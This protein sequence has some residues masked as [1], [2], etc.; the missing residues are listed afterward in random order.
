M[1]CEM[2]TRSCSL[3]PSTISAVNQQIPMNKPLSTVCLAVVTVS[4]PLIPAG[5]VQAAS[6][7]VPKTTT[8][9]NGIRIAAVFFPE[10]TNV[11]IFTFF[12]LGLAYDGPRQAQWSHLVEHLVIRSTVPEGLSTANAETMPDSL[13]LDFY[14][15]V[16]NWETGLSQHRRWLEGVPFT[17]ASLQREKPNVKSDCGFTARNLA[18]HKFAMA[19]WAQGMRHGETNIALLGDIDR[20]S[21]SQIQAYRD[22]HLALLSNVV[23]CV[24]GGVQPSRVLS[25]ASAR[26]GAIKSSATPVAPVKL[27]PGNREMTWDLNARH[28]IITWPAP[29]TGSEDFAPLMA[30]GQWL[31]MRFFSDPEIKRL[32]GMTFAGA[33]LATPEGNFFYISASL[34]PDVSFPEVQ[35][36]LEQQVQ[37]LSSPDDDL[38]MLPMLGGQLAESL[39]TM[40]DMTALKTQLPP[41][42]DLAMVQGNIGLQWGMQEF[43]YGSRKAAL[44]KRLSR[45]RAEDVR[46]A[47]K[48]HLRSAMCSV[49]T[50]RAGGHIQ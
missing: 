42:T 20:V 28:L 29:A 16:G 50:I 43:R 13:R 18:T 34:R 27:H 5:E 35:Q 48:L 26:L 17:E 24:V 6:S 46:R 2:E 39:T 38:S 45:L 47:V 23:V 3:S 49:T 14:G 21:L 4:I 9:P 41:N 8:L 40:P 36:K 19:A 11:S 15:N 12:P 22:E 37:R 30:A 44:A 7:S 10:S 1:A 31:N 33:D 32:T 25:V